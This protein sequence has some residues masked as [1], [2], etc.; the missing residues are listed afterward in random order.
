V[1]LFNEQPYP[2]CYVEKLIVY[3]LAGGKAMSGYK[4]RDNLS[5]SF[6]S[7][8]NEKEVLRRWSFRVH[9]SKKLQNGPQRYFS[10]NGTVFNSFPHLLSK[11]SLRLIKKLF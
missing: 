8:E 4:F 7:A 5:Q 3:H 1:A 9:Q 10:S 6:L 2:T 11:L